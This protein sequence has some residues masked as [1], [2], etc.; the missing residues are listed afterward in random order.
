MKKVLL[1]LIAFISYYAYAPPLEAEYHKQRTEQTY[2]LDQFQ[3]LNTLDTLSF[4]PE[5]L[6]K[7]LLYLEVKQPA[8]VYCQ[9]VLETGHFTSRIWKKYNNLFGMKVAKKR[10]CYA[11]GK[12]N[13]PGT[14]GYRHWSGSVKDMKSF[15]VYWEKKGWDLENDYNNFL[16]KLPYAMSKNYVKTLHLML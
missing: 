13:K 8:M 5:N 1:L 7:A 2:R 10:Y 6:K 16:T 9:A 15:Q 4:S 12:I 11:Y 14:A 3:F